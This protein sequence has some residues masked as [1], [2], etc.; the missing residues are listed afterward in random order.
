MSKK[1]LFCQEYSCV[2]TNLLVQNRG[3]MLKYSIGILYQRE[4]NERI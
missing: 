1:S 2:I 3:Y 4:N